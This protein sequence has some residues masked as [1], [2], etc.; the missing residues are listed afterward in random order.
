MKKCIIGTVLMICILASSMM[1]LANESKT[2]KDIYRLGKLYNTG[3]GNGYAERNAIEEDDLHSEWE[4]GQFYI[5]G[6]SRQILDDNG[7]PIFLKNAGDEVALWFDLQQDITA[8]DGNKKMYVCDDENGYEKTYKLKKQNLKKGAL[9]VKHTDSQNREQKPQVYID[10][11]AA[12]TSTKADTKVLLCEEGDYEVSLLYEIKD[13]N[14][15]FFDSHKN[16]RIDLKFSVRNGNTM[17][18]PFDV[19]T[20][21]ELTNSVFTENGF[22]IDFANSKYLNV[23]VKKEVLSEG[24]EGLVED[25]RFNRPA[26]DGEQFTEEGIYTI[27]VTNQY[28]NV[29]TEKRIYVGN[30]TLLKAHVVTGLSISE[31]QERISDG[32]AKIDVNGNIIPLNEKEDVYQKDDPDKF[33]TE[34]LPE[35]VVIAI[36]AV[37]LLGIIFFLA[38]RKANSTSK[39]KE[40]S[41]ENTENTGE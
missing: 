37:I 32:K 40:Q 1:V 33:N 21:Q 20:G 36:V 6:F 16:Y 3:K 23:D 9:I 35:K 30:N 18:F 38:K 19:I 26:K 7:T 15:L 34:K 31:I 24:V 12:K 5:K 8:L 41:V 29:T 28:T 25:T 17:I 2:D 39:E 22:Y 4:L 14:F 13:D 11:L 27:T 10:Y